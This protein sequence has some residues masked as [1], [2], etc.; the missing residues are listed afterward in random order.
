MLPG[1][2]EG[3]S[4]T[5]SGPGWRRCCPRV[6]SPAVHHLE[7]TPADRRDPLADPHRGAVAG[8]AHPL[9]SLADGLWAGSTLAARRYLA[10]DPH[11]PAAQADAK[12][13]ITWQ[14]SVDSTVA[15]AH[16]HAAGARNG[17]D[18]QRQAPG[19]VDIE[20]ADH[21]LG[22]SR[23][24]LTSK[25]HLAVEGGQRPL[26]ILVTP[27]PGRRQSPVRGGAGRHP[28]AAAGPGTASHQTR[29][30]AG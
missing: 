5:S 4:P 14:V 11:R 12:G 10:A 6:G 27:G 22:R 19:G 24:G 29:A 25:L 18:R 8:G 1:W 28:G 17:G 30:G 23:G 15:R 9:R 26:S 13:L 21:A 2:D 16:Q 20:P 7:Q 3:T